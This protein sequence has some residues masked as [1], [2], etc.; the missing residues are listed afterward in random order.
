MIAKRAKRELLYGVLVRKKENRDVE[1]FFQP[2]LL[3]ERNTGSIDMGRIRVA[4]RRRRGNSC[5]T[6]RI[7]RNLRSRPILFFGM[8][9]RVQLESYRSVIAHLYHVRPPPLLCVTENFI[10]DFHS[11]ERSAYTCRPRR[12]VSNFMQIAGAE[13]RERRAGVSD[14]GVAQLY[15]VLRTTCERPNVDG[16]ESLLLKYRR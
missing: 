15:Y 7:R 10:R 6:H 16:G 4:Y 12:G 2:S 14:D 11:N 8:Y 9:S 3:G 1:K 5:S 13:E